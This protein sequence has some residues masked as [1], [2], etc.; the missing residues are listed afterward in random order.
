MQTR[1]LGTRGLELSAIDLGCMGLSFGLGPATD[2]DEAIRLSRT[3]V[4]R[5]VTLIDTAEAYRPWT[6]EDLAGEALEPVHDTPAQIAFAWLLAR[7]PWIVPI[8]G[9]RKLHRLE[10]KLAVADVELTPADLDEITTAAST[11]EI[12]GARGTGAENYG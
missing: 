8:P 4:D 2:R 6:N 9:T 5:G 3:A 1:V 11:I 7:K 12:R 10:E